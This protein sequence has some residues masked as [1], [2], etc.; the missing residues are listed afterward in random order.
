MKNKIKTHTAFS[1]ILIFVLLVLVRIVETVFIRLD[2]TFFGEN[3]I[4]KV[5]GVL[6]IVTV[7]QATGIGWKAIGFRK[8][9]F[10]SLGVGLLF[11][12]ATFALAY[13]VEAG[14]LFS[15][16]H[17]VQMQ[18]FVSGF[19]LNGETM[20][21]TGTEFILMCIGFNIINVIM[22]EGVFRGLFTKITSYNHSARFTLIFQSVLFGLWHII[23]P[24][25]SFIDREISLPSF[26]LLSIGYTVLSGMMGI[27]W[28]LLYRM[29]D[30]LYVGMADH[31]FN[32]CIATNLLHV[33]TDTGT[34][35][36]MMIRVLVAQIISFM[37]VCI[38]Y[39][40]KKTLSYRG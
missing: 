22:E 31:F 8:N 32:N 40:K 20:K 36:M 3:F 9:V 28:G 25:R 1:C 24:L 35:E 11:A 38:V 13:A 39:K 2:E 18:V 37:V 14:I 33:V 19:S 21:Y 4:H 10:L 29:T 17:S 12:A 16:G 15:S 23:A 27:K 30:T 7:V 5:F 6:V 26:L 34:D